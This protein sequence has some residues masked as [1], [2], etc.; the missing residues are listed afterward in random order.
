MISD[1]VAD[2]LRKKYR[3]Q[4]SVAVPPKVIDLSAD[5]PDEMS[6]TD[7]GDS[8]MPEVVP[9]YDFAGDWQPGQDLPVDL[10]PRTEPEPTQTNAPRK[11]LVAPAASKTA[12]PPAEQQAVS[13]RELLKQ[14]LLAQSKVEPLDTERIERNRTADIWGNAGQNIS[15]VYL[16]LNKLPSMGAY[17]PMAPELEQ[18]LT[19]RQ[20]RATNALQAGAG[21]EERE[22]LAKQTLE[23]RHQGRVEALQAKLEAAKTKEEE[24]Q[25]KK[26][27]AAEQKEYNR[28]KDAA[29]F[30]L[31]VQRTNA[32]TTSAA[33][34]A[35]IAGLKIE[36]GEAQKASEE[37]GIPFL[38][39]EI[40]PQAGRA[41]KF[42]VEAAQKK[43]ELVNAAWGQINEL[44][45]SI[46][47]YIAKPNINSYETLK[48]Q[49]SS[50]AGA[51]NSAQGQGAM[52]EGEFKRAAGS[53]GADPLDKVAFVALFERLVQGKTPEEASKLML[54]K[55]N[56]VRAAARAGAIGAVSSYR[57]V[58][59]PKKN[60]AAVAVP[61]GKLHVRNAKTGEE[62][63]IQQADAEE[64]KKD[65]FEVVP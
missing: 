18:Y 5:V 43:T 33:A 52:V 15:N 22:D 17:K 6:A 25:A 9:A 40:V 24:A 36:E 2:M 46:K 59:R 39:G 11:P 30:G 10:A 27:L 49:A 48:S 20:D 29:N 53:L 63:F 38:G 47:N 60:E 51:L 26:E 14:R 58:H 35:K 23:E 7:G 55:L 42:E 28:M 31:N 16:G 44:E 8:A 54:A 19:S 4:Q 64:A 65:G 32:A 12:N 61:D 1:P 57:Y 21:L 56:G 37:G 34:Q 41:T 50:V 62:L 3:A 45:K 13:L